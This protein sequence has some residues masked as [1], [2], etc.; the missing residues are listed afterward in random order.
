MRMQSRTNDEENFIPDGEKQQQQNRIS[1]RKSF[2]LFK[3]VARLKVEYLMKHQPYLA[4]EFN[5]MRMRIFNFYA[6]RKIFVKNSGTL[7]FVVGICRTEGGDNFRIF[8]VHETQ[9]KK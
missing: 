3:R 7:Y 6:M 2:P 5:R 9:T 1:F 4:I 8:H